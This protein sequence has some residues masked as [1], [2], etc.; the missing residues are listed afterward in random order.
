MEK[1]PEYFAIKRDL[2]NPLWEN[3]KDWFKKQSKK[4]GWSFDMEYYGRHN[5]CLYSLGFM[6]CENFANFNNNPELITLEYWN[7][8]VNVVKSEYPKRM[9]VWDYTQTLISERIVLG[10]FNGLFLCVIE[11]SETSYN[12]GGF[13][14]T[15]VYRNAKELS[16]KTTVEYEATEEQHKAI[17]ELLK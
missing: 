6:G 9:L 7:K 13:Y 2:S 11:D 12:D 10:N 14:E 16:T 15:V 3:F 4:N 17:K 5:E 1:L 8:C